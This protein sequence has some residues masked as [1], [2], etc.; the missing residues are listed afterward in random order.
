[1][2]SGTLL[3]HCNLEAAERGSSLFPGILR[4]YYSDGKI[5]IGMQVHNMHTLT[6]LLERLLLV[7]LD[8]FMWQNSIC[9]QTDQLMGQMIVK[10]WG[11]RIQQ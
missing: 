9:K 3:A 4:A 10:Q 1:M 7:V 11:Q 6:L 2:W 8:I 5:S